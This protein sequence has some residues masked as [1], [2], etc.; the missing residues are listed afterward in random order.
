MPLCVRR[1]RFYGG[2]LAQ[3][4]IWTTCR[5]GPLDHYSSPD[6]PARMGSA[7]PAGDADGL[8]APPASMRPHWPAWSGPRPQRASATANHSQRASQQ[9]RWQAKRAIGKPATMA[10][11]QAWQANHSASH[12]DQGAAPAGPAPVPAPDLS[13]CAPAAPALPSPWSRP[14][15]LDLSAWSRPPPF[16]RHSCRSRRTPPPPPRL[17]GMRERPGVKLLRP[18]PDRGRIGACCAAHLLITQ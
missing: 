4:Y 15:L 1:S 6:A 8:R 5:A 10:L 9:K 18:H 14:A 16:S 13:P 2:L 7:P 12:R 11:W 17:T 3:G